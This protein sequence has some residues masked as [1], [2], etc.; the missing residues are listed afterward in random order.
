MADDM[1]SVPASAV[2]PQDG[3]AQPTSPAPQSQPDSQAQAKPVNLFELDEF[4]KY[5][6]AKDREMRQIREQSQQQMAQ[7]QAQLEALQ[8]R[9]MPDDQRA[10]FEIQKRDRY[11]QQLQKEMQDIRVEQAR[12]TALSEISRE[13]GAPLDVLLE[14]DN[15]DDAWRR[16]HRWAKDNLTKAQQKQVAQDAEEQRANQVDIGRG[17]SVSSQNEWQAQ[18]D[19]AV[20]NG[21]FTEMY[22]AIEMARRAGVQ[23]RR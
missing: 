23:I 12:V 4:R 5:Q 14:A 22:G 7:M 11:I 18:Y 13:T 6:S 1:T 3:Q 17:H 15:P 21:D 9:D 19:K 20:A 16:G 10:G 8:T 2:P